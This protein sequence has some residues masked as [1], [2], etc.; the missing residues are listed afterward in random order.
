MLKKILFLLFFQPHFYVIAENNI[1]YLSQS[2]AHIYSKP[3]NNTEALTTIACGHPLKVSSTPDNQYKNWLQVELEGQIGYVY[4]D[5][6]TS[7]R[8]KCFQAQFN[9]FYRGLK[10]D[11]EDLYYWGRIN[12]KVLIIESGLLK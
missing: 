1:V 4:K 10:L 9:S 2:F 5:F 8:P 3:F 11:L 7:S 6:T 12:D